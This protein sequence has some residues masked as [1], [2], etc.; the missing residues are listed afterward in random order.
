MTLAGT[1]LGAHQVFAITAALLV[2]PT[3]WLKNLSL[4]SYISG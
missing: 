4:L 2:L 3:V 1:E